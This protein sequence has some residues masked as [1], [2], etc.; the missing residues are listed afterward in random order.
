MKRLVKQPLQGQRSQLEP[1]MAPIHV[2]V[3]RRKWKLA[4]LQMQGDLREDVAV[5]SH[6]PRA[7]RPGEAILPYRGPGQ[8]IR[9]SDRALHVKQPRPDECVESHLHLRRRIRSPRR[10]DKRG[11]LL[12]RT[13][14]GLHHRPLKLQASCSRSG[15]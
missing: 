12:D 3:M 10:L 7:G 11:D 9:H 1:V 14:P 5:Q 6:E 4:G 13:L 8:G 2:G 15:S